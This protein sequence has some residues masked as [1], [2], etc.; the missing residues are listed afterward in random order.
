MKLSTGFWQTFKESPADAE[1]P[2]HKLM[3]R[4]GL[5]HKSAAGIFS[6]QPFTLRVIQKIE[7]IIREEL[8]KADCHEIL[9]SMV[10]PGE[11][12]QESKRWDKMGDLML[13]AKDRGGRDVCLSPTNEEAVVDVF[14]KVVKSYKQLPLT[15]YQINT[16]FRDEI[17]PRFGIMR[18]REFTMKD[19]YSFHADKESLD[20]VYEK[21]H[22]TYCDIFNRLGLKFKP[23]EADGGAIAEAGMKTHEFQVLAETGED[24]IINCTKCEYAANV[25]RANTKRVNNVDSYGEKLEVISTPS[26]STITDV[27]NLLK[28]EE[29]QC[30]KSLV[31]TYYVDGKEFHVLVMILGDDELNE[32]K[33]KNY[34]NADEVLPANESVLKAHNLEKGFIGPVGVSDLKVVFDNGVNKDQAYVTG[35]NKVDEHYKGF[36]PSRDFKGSLE[37]TDLRESKQNDLCLN[38]NG[39]IEEIRGIEVAHIFQLGS[40]YTKALNSTVLDKNGKAINPL[41]GCYGI[42]VT[43]IVAASIEQNHDDKGIVWPKEI[44]P[45]HVYFVSIAKSDEVKQV[46]DKLYSE[47]LKADIE[48]VYDDRNAG[49]GFKFKDADLLGLPYQLV[50]GE[51]DFKADGKLEIKNRKTGESIKVDP[52]EVI[53]KLKSL[54]NE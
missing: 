49:P 32:I 23:V 7:G 40:Q 48:V 30:L 21:L 50:L 10:T 41:M 51:R 35:V 38:C 16:K 46:S 9:M 31:Y 4:A 12:W 17:R 44:A 43:R 26:K 29:S 25:E 14:R 13:K 6:Y 34:L 47:L 33:L 42:G 18:G 22:S 2:S 45:Y 36:V 8:N 54:I 3:M 20:E 11:L 5:L 53:D 27:A 24:K 28:I 39:K 19:A 37:F 15:L 52:T 1:I